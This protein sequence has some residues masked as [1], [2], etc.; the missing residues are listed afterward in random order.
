MVTARAGRSSLGC[1]VTLLF[2]VAAGYF[3]VNVGEVYLRYYRF[4]DAARQ[5]LRFARMRTDADIRRR[6][7]AKADSIGIP[8][9]GRRVRVH[10]TPRRITVTGE[11]TE[12]VELPLTVR[13]L[14]FRVQEER[15]F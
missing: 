3:A 7:I 10:R 8:E 15:T 12:I 13:D 6:L 9:L 4:R 5:E 11:Y 2:I 1:L 14:P